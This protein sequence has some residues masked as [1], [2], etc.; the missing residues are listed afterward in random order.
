MR[1][2]NVSQ[3]GDGSPAAIDPLMREIAQPRD[4]VACLQRANEGLRAENAALQSKNA[5]P[6][7]DNAALRAEVAELW[8]RLDLD[9]LMSSKPLSS[10]GFKKKPRVPGSLRGRSGKTS[11]GQAGHKSGTLKQVEARHTAEA[12]GR[13]CAGLSA[14]MQ[15]RMEKRQV[16]NVPRRLIDA[17]EHQAPVC[18]CAACGSPQG[19]SRR[20]NTASAS[21]RRRS[22]S[23]S[24]RGSPRTL[25]PRR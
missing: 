2:G 11:G 12:C 16:F 25:S 14:R 23:T 18:P 13:C 3:G 22:I 10:D 5:G 1:G 9:S 15:T 21:G 19:S 20:P 4:E 24:S 6:R 7:A 17:T 8:R